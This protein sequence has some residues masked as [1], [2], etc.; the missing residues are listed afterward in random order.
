MK[1]E[2]DFSTRMAEVVVPFAGALLVSQ[3]GSQLLIIL[4]LSQRGY[5]MSALLANLNFWFSAGGRLKSARFA[6]Y[7]SVSA[8]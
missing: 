6:E 4:R 1:L 2:A 8:Q 3:R 5:G 7:K